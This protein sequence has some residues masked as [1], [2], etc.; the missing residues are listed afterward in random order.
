MTMPS[1]S[2]VASKGVVGVNKHS[3]ISGSNGRLDRLAIGLD[4]F[5][6]FQVK[7]DWECVMQDGV[8]R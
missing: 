1:S 5:G 3:T 2:M 6:P 7:V 8:R 4:H